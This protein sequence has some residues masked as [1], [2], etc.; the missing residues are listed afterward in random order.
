LENEATSGKGLE[1]RGEM[2]LPHS[3]YRRIFQVDQ[4]D[5]WIR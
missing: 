4:K 1:K 3:Y 2:R 5:F